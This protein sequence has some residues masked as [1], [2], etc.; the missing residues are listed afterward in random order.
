MSFEEDIQTEIEWQKLLDGE[1]MRVY[2]AYS[3][4]QHPAS[5]RD[6]TPGESEGRA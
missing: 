3:R 1:I 2:R 6:T 5:Q 4:E